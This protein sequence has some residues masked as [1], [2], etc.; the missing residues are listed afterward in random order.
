MIVSFKSTSILFMF[1][2]MMNINSCNNAKSNGTSV[3]GNEDEFFKKYNLD[4]IKLPPGFTINV[5]AEVDKAR[6]MCLSPN[7]TLFVGNNGGNKCMLLLMKTKMELLI[8]FTQL[9][10]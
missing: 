3:S 6:S 8:K 2:T 7:G 5:Y 9:L 1:F 4:K 10:K